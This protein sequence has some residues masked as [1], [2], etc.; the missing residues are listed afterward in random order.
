MPGLRNADIHNGANQHSRR[1]QSVCLIYP[2]GLELD[3]S[4]LV[5]RREVLSRDLVCSYCHDHMLAVTPLYVGQ[6]SEQPE[7]CQ[8]G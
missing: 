8:S 4:L 1:I 6:D 5:V 7:R 3:Q 2:A